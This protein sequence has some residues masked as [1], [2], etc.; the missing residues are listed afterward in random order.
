MVGYEMDISNYTA[1]S[2]ARSDERQQASPYS[3]SD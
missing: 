3:T 2:G 1:P